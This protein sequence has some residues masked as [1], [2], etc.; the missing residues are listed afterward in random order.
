ML[1]NGEELRENVA[2]ITLRVDV[3]KRVT[4]S[5][6]NLVQHRNRNA[7]SLGY[8]SKSITGT[9][10]DSIDARLI[11]CFVKDRSVHFKK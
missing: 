1:G 8:V 2:C 9:V 11:V 7:L 3:S 4:I 6:E 10:F 5:I